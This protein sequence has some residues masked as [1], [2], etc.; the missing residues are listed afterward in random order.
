MINTTTGLFF[1]VN[2]QLSVPFQPIYL[3]KSTGPDVIKTLIVWN[4]LFIPITFE[5]FQA[6]DE[7][8]VLVD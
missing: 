6:L 1:F 5:L 4:V 3:E 8:G 7:T 2:S